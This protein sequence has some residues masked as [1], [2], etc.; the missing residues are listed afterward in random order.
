M[1][2]IQGDGVHTSIHTNWDN[3]L[4]FHP[5]VLT[6]VFNLK[7][8]TDNRSLSEVFFCLSVCLNVLQYFEYSL[9]FFVFSSLYPRFQYFFFCDFFSFF[10]KYLFCLSQKVSPIRVLSCLQLQ[11]ICFCFRFGFFGFVLELRFQN[12]CFCFSVELICYLQE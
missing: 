5:G 10:K 8:I 2:M 9:W 3:T 4:Y 12:N 1:L 7:R 11:L 6:F